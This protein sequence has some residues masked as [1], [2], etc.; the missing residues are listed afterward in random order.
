MLHAD[1]LITGLEKVNT[2]RP[3]KKFILT[4]REYIVQTKF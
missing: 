2:F 3:L 4:A 1:W